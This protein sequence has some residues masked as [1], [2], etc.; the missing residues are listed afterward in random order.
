MTLI[1]ADV[2]LHFSR[3]T[4]DDIEHSLVRVAS[5]INE[6][7]PLGHNYTMDK[8]GVT[9]G[10]TQIRVRTIQPSMPP[11]TYT[12]EITA[13]VTRAFLGLPGVT[14]VGAGGPLLLTDPA[15]LTIQ[16]DLA[17]FDGGPVLIARNTANIAGNQGACTMAVGVPGIVTAAVV[18]NNGIPILF[19]TTGALLTGLTADTVVYV[20]NRTATTFQVSATVGG[21]AIA[22]SGTQSGEQ[23]FHLCP[24]LIIEFVQHGINNSPLTN[25]IAANALTK[26][27]DTFTTVNPGGTL[28]HLETIPARPFLLE[29]DLTTNR[30]PVAVGTRVCQIV[31][32]D[33]AGADVAL[34]DL[35]ITDTQTGIFRVVLDTGEWFLEVA[36]SGANTGA[37][38]FD[39]G[40]SPGGNG[41]PP[42]G[43]IMWSTPK[44]FYLPSVLGE[45]AAANTASKVIE[46]RPKYREII[47]DGAGAS[48]GTTISITGLLTGSAS[49][50][51]TYLASN[52]LQNHRL[53]ISTGWTG[54][55]RYPT[56][57]VPSP[58]AGWFNVTLFGH[59]L[60]A[61]NH[62]R[63]FIIR[64]GN[65]IHIKNMAFRVGYHWAQSQGAQG[66]SVD[67]FT[68]G[69]GNVAPT[70]R[71]LIEN[72]DFSGA[73]DELE[74]VKN[75]WISCR[76]VMFLN[77]LFHDPLADAYQVPS[78]SDNHEYGPAVSPRQSNIVYAFCLFD[79]Y[80]YR[81]PLFN[82]VAGA[83]MI[84]NV[85]TEWISAGTSFHM[86]AVGAGYETM[87]GQALG[88]LYNS[89]LRAGSEANIA[90][91]RRLAI[92][93]YRLR[94]A[95]TSQIY[96]PSTGNYRNYHTR[97]DL[98][99]FGDDPLVIGD[100]LSLDDGSVAGVIRDEMPYDLESY[101]G[102]MPTATE[103][104]RRAVM[105]RVLDYVGVRA[106]DGSGN[107]L[108]GDSNMSFYGHHV[109]NALR[110]TGRRGISQPTP[111]LIDGMFGPGWNGGGS[112]VSGMADAAP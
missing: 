43:T 83:T 74:R 102:L 91:K 59:R 61:M 106:T 63:G 11:G 22:F 93:F 1:T 100:G 73:N 55:N 32:K 26:L 17:V 60:W 88:N 48:P 52:N 94:D 82:R 15:D 89:P 99:A 21:P 33:A 49:N 108:P 27:T 92:T 20:V 112:L 45:D 81:G 76:G 4:L 97:I 84:N 79:H 39:Y 46:V 37:T 68:I 64:H 103:A 98:D 29:P 34:D 5:A 35:T 51:Y 66:G 36:N 30:T 47:V 2:R 104:N 95:N 107:V 9:S 24:G 96:I 3:P 8:A 85:V 12:E 41:A 10:L 14:L 86:G 23:R 69:D 25:P 109:V 80:R 40:I 87:T 111:T 6:G 56:T 72:C 77:C 28:D 38:F 90:A 19:T 75:K 44:K 16:F 53:N 67:N 18:P 78:E 57:F 105:A 13:A 42:A 71:I 31:G 110:T 101:Y 50:L 54:V 58:G 7:Q 70:S 62:G 65:N